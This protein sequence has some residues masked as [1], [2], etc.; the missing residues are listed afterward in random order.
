[1]RSFLTKILLLVLL[2]KA[3]Q[4][5]AENSLEDVLWGKKPISRS[6]Q[7]EELEKYV[8]KNDG[9]N[10]SGILSLLPQPVGVGYNMIRDT[11]NLESK[12][13]LES[14][15]VE[16]VRLTSD[17]GH[18]TSVGSKFVEQPSQ[19]FNIFLRHLIH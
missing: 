14:S 7:F 4:G 3:Q 11:R 18:V 16:K 19:F 10:F 5:F 12:L 6:I 2:Y 1:M 15:L 13:L 8:L 9:E 17:S